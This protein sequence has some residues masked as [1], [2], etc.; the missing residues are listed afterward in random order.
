MLAPVWKRQ[1]RNHPLRRRVDLLEAWAFLALFALLVLGAPAAG[2][3][4]A[5]AVYTYDLG[6]AADQEASRRQVPAVVVR[7]VPPADISVGETGRGDTVRALVRWTALEGSPDRGISFVPAGLERGD[8]TTVWLDRRGHVSAPPLSHEH[9]MAGAFTVGAATAGAGVG[10]A[11]AAGLVV[12]RAAGR[13]RM[14]VWEREWQRVG[15]SWRRH[16]A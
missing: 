4:A 12:R 2:A 11:A 14:T 1:W 10:A 6:V 9:I 15:P 16:D 3:A 7:R 13:Y 5:R 8:R